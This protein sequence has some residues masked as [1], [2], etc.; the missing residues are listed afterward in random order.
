MPLE[1]ISQNILLVSIIVISA[2]GLLWPV[3]AGGA[4]NEVSPAQATLLIN[5]ENANI[6]DVR[7]PSEFAAGHLPDALNIPL[8]K[9]AE[10][11]GE[12]E[13]FKDK[14][15]IVCCAAGMRSAK[16][17]GELGKL[18]FTRAHSLAGGVDAWVGAGYPIKKGSGKK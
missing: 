8:D 5:R 6:I 9:L 3:L 10:R 17:C 1:F 13:K 11:A 18:G 15:L 14:P 7:E 12:I 16:G 2:A 4:R